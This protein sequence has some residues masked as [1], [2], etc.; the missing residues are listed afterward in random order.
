MADQYTSAAM[1]RVK[2]TTEYYFMRLYLE[3]Q[4]VCIVLIT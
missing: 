4:G 3:N 2:D 1:Q